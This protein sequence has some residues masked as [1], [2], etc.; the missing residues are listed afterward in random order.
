[1]LVPLLGFRFATLAMMSTSRKHFNVLPAVPPGA[2]HS[3]CAFWHVKC[4]EPSQHH[5]SGTA[6]N[7]MG[8]MLQPLPQLQEW[9]FPPTSRVFP[10]TFAPFT[11]TNAVSPKSHE[12]MAQ[13][14][15]RT[16]T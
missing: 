1:M 14:R 8:A 13:Y 15:R 4:V 11:L 6:V 3:F 7:P 10:H 9:V 5:G 2:P 16:L 12:S